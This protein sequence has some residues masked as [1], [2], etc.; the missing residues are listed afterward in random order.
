M[1]LTEQIA[2]AG[3]V[4]CGGAGFPTHVKLKGN[5][6]YLIV[7]GAECEPLLRNDRWLMRNRAEKIVAAMDA[8]A[9]ELHIPNAVLA[10]KEHYESERAALEEAIRKAGSSVRLHLLG[11]F[12]PA[13]DEQ[14]LVYEVTGR[15][16][17]PAG[18]PAEVGAVVCNAATMYSVGLALKGYPFIYKY[19]TVTGE[20]ERPVI[21]CVPIGTS[22]SECIALA[23][24][25]KRSDCTIVLGGPMMGR[26][27]AQADAADTPVT[28]TTSAVLVLPAGGARERADGASV[29]AMLNRARSACIQCTTCTQLCPRHML[30]H[31]IEPHRIMRKM[32][33]GADVRAL[34]DD[35]DV[36]NAQIC[37][38]CGVCEVYACPMGL[39]PRRINAMLKRE[40]GAAGVRYE[41]KESEWRPNPQ[42]EERKAPSERIAARA[43]VHAYYDYDITELAYATPSR[44]AIPL[45][46]SA[47][48]AAEPRVTAG[49][50][51]REG[52]LIATVPEGKLGANVHASIAGT[53]TG[54]TDRIVI[55]KGSENA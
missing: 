42:R 9:A 16:V 28:K 46:M 34:L 32:A 50:S 20:V 31:P 52:D 13:G 38:E 11:S 45:K 25:A 37:C 29:R 27:L 17:P 23:G 30:G 19:L 8:V 54:V 7:N 24:G 48:A 39:Q 10:L 15:V 1:N 51:V 21:A 40:L 53:V 36:R 43:G 4:G 44:V 14:T 47:G 3:V 6:E 41:R 5:F 33:T 55:E 49:M 26:P 18:I 12:Y 35:P 2:A 22:V